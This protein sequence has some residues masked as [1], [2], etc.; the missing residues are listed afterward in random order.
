[1]SRHIALQISE[2]GE[3]GSDRQ[4]Y[5][6]R[7]RTVCHRLRTVF[8]FN[9]IVGKVTQVIDKLSPAI[10]SLTFRLRWNSLKDT[11]MSNSK[12]EIVKGGLRHALLE[13]DE[14]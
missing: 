3:G 11:Q 1:M 10:E 5:N 6:T 12:A 9:R 8:H 13:N 4:T 7:E 14:N 2:L